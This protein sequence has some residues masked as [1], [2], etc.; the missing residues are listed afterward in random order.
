MGTFGLLITIFLSIAIIGAI[1]YLLLFIRKRSHDSNSKGPG[2]NNKILADRLK[3][4]K[5]HPLT[6]EEEIDTLITDEIVQET[7][8]LEEEI[9]DAVADEI[10]QESKTVEKEHDS[11]VADILMREPESVEKEIDNIAVDEVTQEL[12]SAFTE[13]DQNNISDL[14]EKTRQIKP[15]NAGGR[16]PGVINE[17]SQQ[18][19]SKHRRPKPEIVCWQKGRQWILAVELPTEFYNN[20]DV[21]ITQ[22]SSPLE[23]DS[24]REYCWRLKQAF[25]KVHVNSTETFEIDLGKKEDNYLLFKL[26]GENRREGRLVKLPSSGDYLVVVPA[27]WKITND[28]VVSNEQINVGYQ[29]YWH[30]FDMADN[31]KMVFSTS[32][33]EKKIQSK[34]PMF[35]LIGSSLN[36]ASGT[37]GTLF[38]ENPPC[39]CTHDITDWNDVG[40]II[41][42]DIRE[43]KWRAEVLLTL[44]VATQNLPTEVLEKQSGWYFLRFY[45]RHDELMESLDFRF[46]RG[47]KKIKIPHLQPFPELED[48]HE[49]VQVEIMHESDFVIE[50]ANTYSSNISV[51]S[52]ENRTILSIPPNPDYDKTIWQIGH[53]SGSKVELT[54][55][56]ERI[57]W[58]LGTGVE[59]P[60]AWK[61]QPETLTKDNFSATSDMAL[62]LRFSNQRW[63][64]KAAVGF[65]REYAR[66]Y[67]VAVTEQTVCIPLRE[68]EVG[69][70][71]RNNFLRVWLDRGGKQ[72][73][74]TVIV[75][76]GLRPD[77]VGYG[78]KRSA[79]AVAMMRKGSG[80]IEING[81]LI[82]EYFKK[83]PSEAKDFW[84]RLCNL[85][86]I[87]EIL[88]QLDVSFRVR[89]SSPDTKQQWKAVTHALAHALE[90]Y[91]PELVSLLKDEGF[92]GMKVSH[93][94][95]E[96]LQNESN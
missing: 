21:V 16:H 10:T 32:K 1:I 38:V 43:N 61:D 70:L 49:T 15:I 18:R 23:K 48:R 58:G 40:T 76:S 46:V 57:W 56:L 25:G 71:Y 66:D 27:D 42:G 87:P 86:S 35:R 79:I 62:W 52:T 33:G 68:F 6:V 5:P 30:I 75:V 47:L 44:E 3:V 72:Y 8:F 12:E 19:E 89:G 34:A 20:G 7:E 17:N 65:Q 85:E 83:A 91:K 63:I 81:L 69:D 13:S 2:E 24:S 45:G 14:P 78:R 22:N 54:I 90:K 11:V 94:E 53:R 77:W 95:E 55:L 9:N 82:M 93:H 39:I 29:A 84:H 26:S 36:G 88:S 80:K 92:G 37:M 51:K 96:G 67:P 28:I 73:E 4:A 59:K 50:S 41:I 31:R 64:N 74:G 60:V